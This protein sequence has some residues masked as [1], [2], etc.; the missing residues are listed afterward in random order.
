MTKFMHLPVATALAVGAAV[1]A[2]APQTPTS[3]NVYATGLE[4]PRG[5]RFGP[6]GDLYVAEAGL[7]G[8]NKTTSTECPQVPQPIGPYSGGDTGRISKV[9]PNGKVTTVASGFAS[10]Q[11]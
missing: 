8:T 5:L 7:G 2:A 6:D 10:A 11:D 3:N 1:A 9:A 4:A